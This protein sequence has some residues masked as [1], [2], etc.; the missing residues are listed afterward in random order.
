MHIRRA[1]ACDFPTVK[2]IVQIT[3][4]AVYP[5]Y[6][7]AGAVEFFLHHHSDRAIQEDITAGR[8]YLCLNAH[9]LAIGT[10]TIQDNEIN[11]LFVL[12]QY[13]GQGYGRTLM[14]FAEQEIAKAYPVSRLSASL[15]AK[16]LYLKNGY[17]S[18]EYHIIAADS[19]DFLCYDLMEK[20]LA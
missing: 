9:Q 7:P 16:S 8:A 6:Y 19:G 20:S 4:R 1:D 2:E 14:T 10:V 17:K 3:I 15:P 13:H 18:L 12:P 5:H 11:R